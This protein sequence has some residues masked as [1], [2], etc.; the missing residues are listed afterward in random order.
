MSKRIM[1]ISVIASMVLVAGLM[2]YAANYN[3]GGLSFNGVMVGP[4]DTDW[5]TL[6]G[7]EGTSPTI[8]LSH[9]GGVDFDVAVFNDGNQVCSNIATGNYTCCSASTPGSVR[10]KIWSVTGSGS[11]S[12]TIRP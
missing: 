1:R 9:G 4:G 10:V 7:Q 3:V 6:Q 11:Y 12:V 5:L 8:C 2:A